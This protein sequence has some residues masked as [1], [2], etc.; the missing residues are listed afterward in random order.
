MDTS[1]EGTRAMMTSLIRLL[2]VCGPCM[3]G[4]GDT[5]NFFIRKLLNYPIL[6]LYFFGLLLMI[7]KTLALESLIVSKS[8]MFAGQE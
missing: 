2:V 3:W 6:I 1:N 5:S 7:F 8:G 4:A